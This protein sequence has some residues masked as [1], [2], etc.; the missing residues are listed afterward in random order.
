M[1]ATDVGN[2]EERIQRRLK[3]TDRCVTSGEITEDKVVI[4]S[5]SN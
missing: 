3:E 2:A 1:K 5:S 4:T